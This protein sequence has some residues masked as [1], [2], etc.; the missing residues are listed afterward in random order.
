MGRKVTLG[1]DELL[2]STESDVDG[3]ERSSVAEYKERLKGL[4]VAK[5]LFLS[6]GGRR[7][8]IS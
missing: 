1:D 8:D 7:V 6:P 4:K 5:F 2:I 3:R